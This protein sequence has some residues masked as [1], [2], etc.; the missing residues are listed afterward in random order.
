M[1]ILIWNM[2]RAIG[3]GVMSTGY[4]TFIKAKFPDAVIDIFCTKL[5]SLA[6]FNNPHIDTILLFKTKSKNTNMP[7][8]KII[9]NPVSQLKNLTL[10]K[11]RQY[12]IIIDTSSVNSF[13][14]RLMLRYISSKNT[15]I[16]GMLDPSKKSKSKYRKLISFYDDVYETCA[17]EIFDKNIFSKAK[18][19][20]FCSDAKLKKA[21]NYFEEYINKNNI[22]VI[23]NGEGSARTISS[24]KIIETCSFLIKQDSNIHIFFLGYEK[25]YDKYNE[26]LKKINSPNIHITYN[27]DIEDTASLIKYAHVLISVDTAVIHIAAAMGTKVCEII[28]NVYKKNYYPGFPRFIEYEIVTSNDTEY[29]LE[30]Y[31]DIDILNAVY[32]LTK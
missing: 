7:R 8:S 13:F 9:M 19:Q 26:I 20:L 25:I 18:Y 10:A 3:D 17:Y 31:K 24:K 12:D 1:K 28:S 11:K 16:Y 23:F 32:K 27:T 29:S 15:K 22:I 2:G 6:F 30:K 4:P 14:N 5:H 21:Y